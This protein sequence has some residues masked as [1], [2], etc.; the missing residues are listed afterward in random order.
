MDAVDH[1]DDKTSGT[2]ASSGFLI[3]Y[4]FWEQ[5]CWYYSR[6]CKTWLEESKKFNF[7]LKLYEKVL[8]FTGQIN[9][10]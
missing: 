9:T 4:F 6:I 8:T 2:A 1:V 3:S 7:G 10:I 5:S